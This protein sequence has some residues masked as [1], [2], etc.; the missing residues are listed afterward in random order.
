LSMDST[1]RSNISVG[2]PL[3]LLVYE[4]GSLCVNHFACITEDNHYF[5]SLRSVWGERLCDIFR[6]APVPA[7]TDPLS[8]DTPAPAGLVHEPIRAVPSGHAEPSLQG[9]QS[10]AQ[11]GPSR[12]PE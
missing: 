3:D 12:S 10:L 7:W 5:R 6:E 1:L 9:V 8:P 11:S 4:A 2:L